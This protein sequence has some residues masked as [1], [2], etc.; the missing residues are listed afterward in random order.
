MN[1]QSARGRRSNSTLKR[2]SRWFGTNL[3]VPRAPDGALGKQRRS[4]PARASAGGRALR[5][6]TASRPPAALLQPGVTFLTGAQR[7][8]SI[9]RRHTQ[10]VRV[11]SGDGTAKASQIRKEMSFAKDTRRASALTAEPSTRAGQC[12]EPWRALRAQRSCWRSASTSWDRVR[13]PPC[14]PH[15]R[16]YLGS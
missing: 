7:D 8:I 11:P 13:R 10:M 2:L 16:R 5:E 1:P 3:Y 9:R 4:C 15:S 6:L 14:G 12:R